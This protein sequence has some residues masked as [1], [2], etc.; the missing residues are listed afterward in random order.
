MPRMH[1]STGMRLL[2]LMVLM[3]QVAG[4]SSIPA[5]PEVIAA[6]R[7]RCQER[8]ASELSATSADEARAL[9]RPGTL[10]A[11]DAGTPLFRVLVPRLSID[12]VVVAGTEPEQM[13]CGAGVSDSTDL[14]GTG[15]GNVIVELLATGDGEVNAFASLR[16]GDRLTLETPIGFFAHDVRPRFNS[17]PNPYAFV[18]QLP[19]TEFM[20]TAG[21]RLLT[22]GVLLPRGDRGVVV[23][24]LLVRG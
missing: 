16:S 1:G 8:L 9:Y 7:K 22:L 23:Q 2:F 18:G 4:C 17:H 3:T 11:S 13:R 21:E 20:H 15:S 5:D 10:A 14:P 19:F 24:G 6:D 12:L